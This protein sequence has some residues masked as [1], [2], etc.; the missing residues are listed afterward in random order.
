MRTHDNMNVSCSFANWRTTRDLSIHLN[1][2]N[3]KLDTVLILYRLA[4]HRFSGRS[5]ALCS[6][7]LHRVVC[8]TSSYGFSQ[9]AKTI[10][11]LID[12]YA[13]SQPVWSLPCFVITPMSLR[14]VLNSTVQP[15]KQKCLRGTF[16]FPRRIG[17]S[18]Y[19]LQQRFHTGES[20]LTRWYTIMGACHACLSHG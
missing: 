6:G 9:C 8:I 15:L 11:C 2:S 14:D 18:R 16:H 7:F 10:G 5:T 3:V 1:G 19:R 13:I 17:L 20:E 12:Q 4:L